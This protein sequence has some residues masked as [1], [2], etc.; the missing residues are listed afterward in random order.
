VAVDH[1][2]PATNTF[3]GGFVFALAYG[4]LAKWARPPADRPGDLVPE[5]YLA[6]SVETPDR[7]AAVV[8]L[9]E[10]AR[11][12][13]VRPVRGRPM[14]SEDVA[15][16]IRRLKDPRVGSPRN[17]SFEPVEVGRI[18]DE[19]S[20]RFEFGRPY[21]PF[22]NYIADVWQSILAVEAIERGVDWIRQNVAG[23]GPYQVSKF[24]P[25][26]EIELDAFPLDWWAPWRPDEPAPYLEGVTLVVIGGGPGQQTEAL[27]A[28]DLDYAPVGRRAWESVLGDDR[29]AST[30]IVSQNVNTMRI[31]QYLG[32][33]DDVRV[34]QALSLALD[35]DEVVERAFDGDRAVST[36]PIPA[37]R[38]PW[39]QAAGDCPQHTH[40]LQAA[41]QLLEAAGWAGGLQLVNLATDGA[42][43]QQA[44]VEVFSEQLRRAGIE[45]IQDVYEYE[46][47]LA[48]GRQAKADPIGAG[49]HINMHQGNRYSDIGQYAEEFR[50]DSG[51]NYGH[52]GSTD[53]DALIAAQEQILDPEERLTAIHEI[54]QV[55]AEQAYTPG[56][57]LPVQMTAWDARLVH[58]ADGPEWFQGTRSFI[59]AWLD[60]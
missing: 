18:V 57:V 2:D 31:N 3:A 12:H 29:L 48:R 28:G 41:R 39:G 52:W 44:Y 42:P 1:L 56:L 37:A 14:T 59:D 7:T 25:A 23:S 27:L 30:L 20:V 32:P 13:D 10:G 8:T 54:N 60:P 22:F 9:R 24:A 53:L 55:V 46:A 35:R 38:T 26:E 51:R 47:Y 16:T 15:A 5:P 36:G 33:M 6:E 58:M 11:F 21:P 19:R 4:Q 34:R 17:V 49:W 40:D 45:V 50:T 43:D